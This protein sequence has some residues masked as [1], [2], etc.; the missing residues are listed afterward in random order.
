V[1]AN[2]NLEIECYKFT[3]LKAATD[4]KINAQKEAQKQD[5]KSAKLVP[6]WL[7]NIGEQPMHMVA[8][9]NKYLQQHDIIVSCES[10]VFVLTEQGEIR[11]QRRFDY[12]PS[13][14]KVYHLS[15]KG[16]DIYDED[17]KRSL[18]DFKSTPCFMMLL[19]SFNNFLMVYNDVRLAWTA[20][21]QVAPVFVDIANFGDSKG[22]I[23]TM[24]DSGFL[25][26]NYLGTEQL[27]TNAQALTLKDQ[28]KV[29]FEAV[30]Q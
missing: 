16:A 27:S 20:K 6:D 15:K 17:N 23:V 25:Q 10:M 11:H 24:S 12:M 18:G 26:V 19:G 22:L 28:K 13:C 3:T 4:N 29:D 7:A 8:H 1:I 5:T 21:T 9:F 14:L 30:N 2:S